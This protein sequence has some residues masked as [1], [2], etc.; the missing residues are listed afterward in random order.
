MP[1]WWC[2][3]LARKQDLCFQAIQDASNTFLGSFWGIWRKSYVC[4]FSNVCKWS[5]P[6]ELQVY[7]DK[8]WNYSDTMNWDW[9]KLNFSCVNLQFAY[10]GILLATH[11]DL[12]QHQKET[13]LEKKWML[14]KIKLSIACLGKMQSE[15]MKTLHENEHW[16]RSG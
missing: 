2:C 15:Y 10:F 1:V 9:I 3:K 16:I 12:T 13:E 4:G 8:E 11:R 5:A 6:I 14:G 7:S